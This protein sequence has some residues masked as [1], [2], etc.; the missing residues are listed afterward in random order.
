[1]KES[2]FRIKMAF[3]FQ[4]EQGK[5]EKL[6][7]EDI[8]YAVNYTDAENVAVAL[9]HNDH[10]AEI[11]EPEYEIVKTKISD[12]RPSKLLLLNKDQTFAGLVQASFDN[13]ESS[14]DGLYQVKVNH[15]DGEDKDGYPTYKTD[16]VWVFAS[17]SD[18]AGELAMKRWDGCSPKILKVEYDKAES[19]IVPKSFFENTSED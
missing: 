16:A 4:N 19:I 3:P 6:K 2:Y 17:S 7:V 8:V 14:C 9:I 1:M 10:R 11:E 5:T 15:I 13:Q 18:H 12:L